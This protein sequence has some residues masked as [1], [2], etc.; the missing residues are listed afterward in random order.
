MVAL[1]AAGA[2]VVSTVVGAPR[3]D[4]ATTPASAFEAVTPC[5]LLDT[6]DDER[7]GAG[8]TV[9]IQVAGRCRVP[10]G[11]TAVAVTITVVQPDAP[12]FVVGYAADSG[13][14]VASSVNYQPGEVVANLQLLQLGSGAITVYS[15]AATDLVV[16]VSGAFLP[17]PSGRAQAGR[18]VPTEPAR[19]VDT[20]DTRRPAPGTTLRVRTDIPDDAVAVAVNITTTE[21]EGPDVF[22]AFAAGGR[23]PHASS[24]NA[25][26]PGQTRAAAAIVPVGDG[27]IDVYT[28][29]GNHVIVDVVGYYT[30]PSAPSSATGLFVADQPTRLVDTREEYGSSGGPRLWA[31]G[32]REFSV[33]ALAGGP[34]SAVAANVTVTDTE[35]AG[36]VAVHPAGTARPATSTLNYDRSGRTVANLAM[37]AVSERGI[38]V[39]ALDSTDLVVDITGWFTGEPEKSSGAVPKNAPPPDR[40]VTI[41]GDSASAGMRWNGALGG[42]QGFQVDARLESCR[43][44]VQWSCRGREGYVPRTAEAEIQTLAP[45]G[46]DDMLVVMTGYNDWH[47]RFDD[48]FDAVVGAARERGF[49]HIV[50]VDYRSNAGY[51]PPSGGG[52]SNYGEM[53]RVIG[54]KLASGAFPEVRRWHFDAYTSGTSLWFFSDGVHETTFG[55]WGVA[56]WI[57]RHVRAFD[58][59]PCAQPLRPGEPVPNPCPDPDT[60][61]G[62]VGYPDIAG[63]Y[64]AAG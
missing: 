54:E 64:P 55:S 16:D 44:L 8:D 1:V 35:D 63:L 18:F 34:V 52:R 48:D 40:R 46:I 23:V 6:R 4:A 39:F 24:L 5:R 17:A 38:T 59:R 47:E 60:L 51:T 29:R 14:P 25:D 9:E 28:L 10:E 57:S 20:R 7:L 62:T 61:P 19:V 30:G 13:R 12:G 58:D 43:R 27:D 49:H 33:E 42:L 11:A 41:I 3:V 22:T 2:A 15:L 26:A 31:G 50:W 36:F 37:T 56:D 53:N 32:A 21:T 45:A